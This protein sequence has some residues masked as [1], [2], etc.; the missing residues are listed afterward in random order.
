[1]RKITKQVSCLK[2]IKN[3]DGGPNGTQSSWVHQ[4]WS[5]PRPSFRSKDKID[6][7]SKAW[8][9]PL[10]KQSR[11]WGSP[12]L[13][14]ITRFDEKNN[15]NGVLVWFFLLDSPLITQ[16]IHFLQVTLFIEGTIPSSSTISEWI[17]SHKAK[18]LGWS[19]LLTWLTPPNLEAVSPYE[20]HSVWV[21]Y[22]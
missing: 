17:L 16:V 18:I 10:D 15:Q 11:V 19:T 3:G 22:P 9:S 6:K 5:R 7:Q 20:I 13:S 14:A 2:C 8:G 4:H 1:M 21:Q 12:L